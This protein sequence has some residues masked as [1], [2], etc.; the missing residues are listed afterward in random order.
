MANPSRHIVVERDNN[1]CTIRLRRGRMN[2]ADILEMS[3]QIIGLIHDEGC[4]KM[5][6]SL[7]P[8]QLECLYSVFLAKLVMIRRIMNEAGGQLKLCDASPETVGVFEA[9]HL[10]ELFDFQPDKAAAIK[11]LAT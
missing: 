8:G 9:C 2:E 1:V 3:D 11:A 4:R 7:G 6:I 5:V 10:K